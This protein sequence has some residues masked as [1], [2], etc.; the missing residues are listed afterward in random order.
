MGTL[1]APNHIG[2]SPR[3]ERGLKFQ[4][5]DHRQGEQSRS[6]YGERGLKSEPDEALD[7]R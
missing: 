2:R 4:I 3:G 7:V 1:P 5:A 6:P